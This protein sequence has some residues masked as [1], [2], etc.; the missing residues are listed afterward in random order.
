MKIS[1]AISTSGDMEY[2]R[3]FALYV[4][5]VYSR[6]R[7]TRICLVFVISI[8]RDIFYLRNLRQ[9]IRTRAV[10]HHVTRHVYISDIVSLHIHAS[11]HTRTHAHTHTRARARTHRSY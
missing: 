7:I 10:V 5:D 6:C 1:V 3:Q 4:D 8:D 2:F 9:T 11:T